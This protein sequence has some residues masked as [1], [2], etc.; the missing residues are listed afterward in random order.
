M[1][2]PVC[3]LLGAC[4][5]VSSVPKNGVFRT[6][7]CW[8]SALF[9]LSAL[10]LSASASKRIRVT[11]RYVPGETLRYRIESRTTTSGK[12][13]TPILN[14]EGATESALSMHLLVRLDVLDLPA[15]ARPGTI[16]FRATYEES[17]VES[18]S[19]AFDPAEP[20]PSAPYVH[21]QGRS[22]EF[23]V[24]PG[25]NLADLQG[26]EDLFPD[27]AAARATLS[28]F[29]A[30]SS[31]GRFPATDIEIGE[32]WKSEQ[33]I[34][35]APVSDLMWRA[36]SRYLRDEPCPLDTGTTSDTS[37]ENCVAI[38]TRFTISRRGSPNSDATPDDYLHNGLRVSG[39]WTG[40]G[41]RLDSISV[42]RSVLVRST[43]SSDQQMD[44]Q[45]TR[46]ATGASIHNQSHVQ[47]QSETSLVSAPS[48]S[49]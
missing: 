40:S 23:T 2:F 15:G 44:Y 20:S 37:V 45:I 46:A 27:P 43:Q 48:S 1:D 32:R 35:G 19:D 5:S 47:F 25:G 22:L 28:W 34:D 26:L 16:R 36:E 49:P 24:E 6:S 14:P 10:A 31:G 9:C 13:T 21:L 18:Q 4:A 38:L 17:H 41:E 29:D 42:S 12:I 7:I 11:L 33:R 3:L 30:L 8:F 39:G